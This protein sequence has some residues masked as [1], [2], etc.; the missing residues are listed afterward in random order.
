MPPIWPF[1][2][3][4]QKLSNLYNLKVLR[5]SD[6]IVFW[7]TKISNLVKNFRVLT[8]SN[9]KTGVRQY[10]LLYSFHLD[11]SINPQMNQKE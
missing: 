4:V 5:V 2:F 9:L 6:F 1:I 11:R 10:I 3:R 7:A 8:L